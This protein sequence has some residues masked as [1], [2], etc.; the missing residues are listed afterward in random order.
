MRRRLVG[1]AVAVSLA[2]L[3]P[4]VSP[5]A[6][7]PAP[8][9]ARPRQ[10]Q[11]VLVLYS[12]RRDTQFSAAGD[13]LV[14]R[15]LAQQI[16]PAPDYFGE[17]MDAAR[18]PASTYGESFAH[19]LTLKYSGIRFDAV[20]AMHALAYDFVAAH[21]DDLFAGMPVV[22]LSEEV[23]PVRLP[24]AAGAV[25]PR[26]FIATL[27]LATTLQPDTTQVLVVSGHSA[28]DAAM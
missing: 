14:P 8:A 4:S 26:D 24:N 15:L 2:V 19:Y 13:R 12:T 9:H 3:P 27:K 7:A 10:Q 23:A 22:F 17:Y 28:R 11:R 21:R 1:S 20:I 18:F 6:A 5:M 25:A 16:A